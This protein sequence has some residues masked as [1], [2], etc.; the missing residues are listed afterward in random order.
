MTLFIAEHTWKPEDNLTVIKAAQPL[1]TGENL[2]KKLKLHA[3][4]LYGDV[5]KAICIW[6]ADNI[7]SLETIFDAMKDVLPCENKFSPITQFYPTIDLR[8]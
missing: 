3:T 4:Y 7:A 8:P 6:E 2:P 1:F 5:M